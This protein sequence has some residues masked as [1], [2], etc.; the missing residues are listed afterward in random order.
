MT[1]R[2]MARCTRCYWIK[3]DLRLGVSRLLDGRAGWLC[4]KCG[5]MNYLDVEPT[6]IVLV[7]LAPKLVTAPPTVEPTPAVSKWVRLKGWFGGA[8][9]H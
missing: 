2:G 3:R 5:E 1:F 9:A 8:N 7:N 4:G 6:L